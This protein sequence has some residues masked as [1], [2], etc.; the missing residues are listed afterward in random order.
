MRAVAPVT[1]KELRNI[2]K[3]TACGIVPGLVVQVVKLSVGKLAK[4]FA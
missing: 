4:Y 3:T 2:Q 1:D